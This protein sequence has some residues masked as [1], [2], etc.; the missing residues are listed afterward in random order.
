[1]I[2]SFH[3]CG[4]RGQWDLH[5][6]LSGYTSIIGGNGSGKTHILEGI[7]LAS[8]GSIDYIL[9]PRTEDSLFEIQYDEP[10]GVR[11]FSRERREGKDV[12]RIQGSKI[13]WVKYLKEF[14]YR[15]VFLSPF[16]M[17]LFYFA[18]SV[19]RACI[20]GILDRA[21][22]QFRTVKRRYDEILMQRNS[23]L[24]KIREGS[25]KPWD[26]KYWDQ[27]FVEQAALYHLYRK[28]WVDFVWEHMGSIAAFLPK[29]TLAHI[30]ESR[31]D[32]TI[33]ETGKSLEEVLSIL[34]CEDQ[35]YDIQ[36]GHT[37]IGA[38][39]DD[40]S[41]QMISREHDDTTSSALYLSRGENK[42]LLLALKQIEILFL[43]KYVDLPIVLL[44]DDIFAELD[45]SY[46]EH[47]ISLFEADQ[48]IMTS[49]RSLPIWKNW[50]CFSCIN[51]NSEYHAENP[52]IAH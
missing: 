30:Y 11:S 14:P 23:L 4:F 19:R 13:S 24:K 20:D 50:E 49:Q 15:T 45:Q 6:E 38:H 35:L 32:T 42:V 39:R 16:D 9:A 21:F 34:L 47:I 17:N 12:F 5:F 51:L 10:I 36:S 27:I 52:V 48:L 37:H 40:F 43:R 44:F 2:T 29:Y 41:F 8:G 18:P 26:L 7:H 28:K 3:T 33:H 31:L 1:M 25:A 46:A 22:A